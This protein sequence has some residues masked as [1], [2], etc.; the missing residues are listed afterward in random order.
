MTMQ[1]RAYICEDIS[2]SVT[3]GGSGGR[4]YTLIWGVIGNPILSPIESSNIINALSKQVEPTF[5]IPANTLSINTTYTITLTIVNFQNNQA[6][7]SAVL[8]TSL[9]PNVTFSQNDNFYTWNQ[10]TLSPFISPYYCGIIPYDIKMIRYNWTLMSPTGLVL[11]NLLLTSSGSDLTFRKFAL[12]PK[13]YYKF[14]ITVNFVRLSGLS[15]VPE[16]NS[17][18][19]TDYIIYIKES[20]LVSFINGGDRSSCIDSPLL[21]DGSQAQDPDDPTKTAMTY[22]WTCTF[23]DYRQ[24]TDVNKTVLTFPKTA[25]IT[26]PAYRLMLGSIYVFSLT[27]NSNGRTSSDKV[28]IT[29]V[30]SNMP[31]MSLNI[32]KRVVVQSDNVI[33]SANVTSKS[34]YTLKY[35]WT[36]YSDQTGTMQQTF[37]LSTDVYGLKTRSIKILPSVLQEGLNYQINLKISD[38]YGT[39]SAQTSLR[40]NMAPRFGKLNASPTIGYGFMTQYVFT[41]FGWSDSDLPLQYKF[42]YWRDP[43]LV[44]DMNYIDDISPWSFLPNTSTELKNPMNSNNMIYVYALCKDSYD[45]VGISATGINLIVYPF[46]FPTMNNVSFF[47]NNKFGSVDSMSSASK[48]QA[49]SLVAQSLEIYQQTGAMGSPV[50]NAQEV[51]VTNQLITSKSFDDLV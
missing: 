11:K 10:I 38:S 20:P 47:Y 32:A 25:N 46:A 14:L 26:I 24:C 4:K 33:V 40:V 2:I 48:L 35:T 31:G 17:F 34:P 36:F 19:S 45:A 21:L 22:T 28:R 41:T 30:P 43:A 5:I 9:I 16:P 44:K 8:D 13:T 51:Q 1:N 42:S 7:A 37:F 12:K 49:A 15:Y 23:L 18:I 29:I 27:V 6:T 50:S 39:V 3:T